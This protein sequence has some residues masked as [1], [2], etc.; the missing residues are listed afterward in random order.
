MQKKDILEIKKRYKKDQATFSKMT[1]CYVNGEKKIVTKFRETFLNLEE[2]EY[3]KYLEIAKKVLTGTVGNNLLELRFQEEVGKI[4][5]KQSFFMDIKRTRLLKDELLD[6][7]YESVIENYHYVGNFIILLFHDAYDVITK[8]EDNLKLDESEEVYEYVLCAVCPVSLSDPGLS[9]VED[10][11]MIRARHR[12]WVVEMPKHGFVYPAFIDRSQDLNAVMYFTKNGKDPH[13]EFMEDILGC[14]MR[15]TAQLQKES[16]QS[17]VKGSLE[18]GNQPSEEI[19]MEV[20]DQLSAMVADYKATYADAD[21]EPMVLTHRDV[22]GIL[23]DNGI[24]ENV[25]KEITESYASYYGEDL[26][27]AESLLD[28]KVLKEKQQREKEE[29]L[30]KEV[31]LLH[32]EL[33]KVKEEKEKEVNGDYD[34]ILRVKEEKV[35]KIRSQIIDGQK[36]IVIPVEEHEQAMINGVEDL[37]K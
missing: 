23:K 6:A 21:V 7:F 20:Q 13:P 1:G 14:E 12:D 35:S 10:E 15:E 33:E 34:V 3:H 2:E 36:C 17:M 37:L 4:S 16:F 9:Y 27:L 26:P 24:P 32:G 29:R 8:T 19:F 11:N 5:E 25:T 28:A 31:S 18:A 30:K 22:E